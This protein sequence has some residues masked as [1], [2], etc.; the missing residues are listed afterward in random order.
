[1]EGQNSPAGQQPT[2]PPANAIPLPAQQVACPRC[3]TLVPEGTRYCPQCGNAIPPPTWPSVPP[4]AQPPKRNTALVIVAIVLVVLLVLGVTGYVVYQNTRQQVLQ[5]AKNSEANAASQAVNQLQLIC[6]TNRT[7]ASQLSYTSGYGYSGYSTIYET[8]GVSNPTNFAMTT[9][10]TFT[11]DFPSPAWVL[12]NTQTFHMSARGVAYPLFA[13]TITGSQLNNTPH[14]ATFTTFSV[15]LDGTYSVTGIYA[16][17]NP[18]THQ[19]Y[20]SST[21]TGNGGPSFSGSGLPKC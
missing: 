10:W 21:N 14:N 7:D 9:T 18:T 2:P 15:T 5:A 12:T 19:T 1:M 11:I 6:F 20:D 17:Y 16:T 8:F 3:Y 13:F 4:I